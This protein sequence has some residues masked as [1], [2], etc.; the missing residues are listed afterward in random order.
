MAPRLN[1]SR[2]YLEREN[3]AFARQLAPD[4]LVLDAGAGIQP[5][6]ALFG[7]CRYEAADFEKVDKP[8]AKSTY[9]CDLASIPVEDGRFDAVLFNQ[10]L[11]HLSEPHAVLHELHRVI[12][13][14]GLMICTVPLFYEEHEQ[15]YDFYRY[16]Q[17]GLRH[18]FESTN[19]KIQ[20]LD[21]M[22]GYFGTVAYQMETA[23]KYLPRRPSAISPGALGVLAAVAFVPLRLLLRWG[24]AALYRLD[25]RQKVTSA[26]FPKN[27]LVIASPAVRSQNGAPSTQ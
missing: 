5:Y 24:E 19:W 6:R 10:V 18:L 15:P 11:E 14:G 22:E 20:R 21:W 23:R 7:H 3:E 2:V 12:K 16:T 25:V 13:P 27:Y 4:S 9:V 26:G 17:F 8:Y 1:S